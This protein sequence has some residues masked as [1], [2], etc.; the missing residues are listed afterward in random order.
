MIPIQRLSLPEDVSA[1]MTILTKRIGLRDVASG[2]R[3][4]YADNL[5]DGEGDV[6]K[7]LREVLRR[8]APGILGCCMYC[9]SCTGT[10][11][12]HFEPREHNSLQTFRWTNHLLACGPC[13]SKYKGTWWKCDE[14]T[15]E[16][17]L[18]DPTRDDPF[19]HLVLNL[20]EGIYRSPTAKGESTIELLGL[21]LPARRFPEARKRAHEN[22]WVVLHNWGQARRDDD[23]KGMRAALGLLTLQPFAD[24]WQAMLRQAVLPGADIV[25]RDEPPWVLPLLRD[26]ELRA[27]TLVE[28]P[29]SATPTT[30]H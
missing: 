22:A 11:I 24:V 7:A 5:W 17:L 3:K 10:D 2:A 26:E 21:N 19:A 16:P 15:G 8:M 23:E 12:E 14:E 27:A 18:V 28:F 4:K 1:R 20:R 30:N 25:M 13:N 6:K 29:V 9:G